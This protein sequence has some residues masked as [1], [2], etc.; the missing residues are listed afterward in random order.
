M[1]KCYNCG[2]EIPDNDKTR[3]CD[4]C[5]KFMLPFVKLVDVSTSS[6][7]RRLVANERNL[8]AVGVTDSGMDYLL[9]ICTVHDK[10][11]MAEKEERLAKETVRAEENKPSEEAKNSGLYDVE[12]PMDEPLNL[13]REKYGSYLPAAS[14]ALLAAGVFL[15]SWAVYLCFAEKTV[16]VAPLAGGIASIAGAYVANVLRKTLS[17]LSEIKK[18]FR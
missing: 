17:D 8:R 4:G 12:L 6:A 10:K 16:S 3:L 2:R 5:K 15:T 7:V 18:M 11:K 13:N 1:A 9:R 14:I